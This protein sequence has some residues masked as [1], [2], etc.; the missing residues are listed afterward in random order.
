MYLNE[1]RQVK[2]LLISKKKTAERIFN[3]EKYHMNFCHEC[4]GLGKTF[5]KDNSLIKD[6]P[7]KVCQ[8]FG[9]FGLIKKEDSGFQ[10]GDR[11]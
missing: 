8:V 10:E 3:P 7:T 9:G 5:N 1:F 4:L 2:R 6:D 11:T